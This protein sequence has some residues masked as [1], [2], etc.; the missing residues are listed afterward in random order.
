MTAVAAAL[1][2][3]L[4][5]PAAPAASTPLQQGSILRGTVVDQDGN[6]IAGARVSVQR[7]DE[8]VTAAS[9]MSTGSQRARVD[10][11]DTDE[12]GAFAVL[13][14]FPS[15]DYR[16]RVEKDG[17]VPRETR[18]TLR[19]AANE[20]DAIMLVSGDVER[21]RDAYERGWDAYRSGRLQD[22]MAPMREVVAAYGDSDSSD[23]MLVA[24]LGVLGQGYLQQNSVAEAG[25]SFERLL[26]ILPDS[27]IAL[28]GLGQVQ[29]MSGQMGPA[30][31]HFERAVEVEPDNANGRFLLGYTLQLSGQSAA[32]IPHLEACLELQPTFA[33]A[34][35]SLGM[36]LADSGDKEAAIEHLEAYL[37]ASPGAPDAAQVQAKVAELKR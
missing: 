37:A 12:A 22:A 7:W 34:H 2:T 13:N 23:E 8:G 6:P 26:S 1:L 16:I 24:A 15:V 20:I 9:V 29:A 31:E 5:L 36:A 32:A 18:M 25:A 35:Q 4:L 14:L 30:L 11:D 33:R 19:V 17:F 27:A 10:T 28:R 21:A 3:A